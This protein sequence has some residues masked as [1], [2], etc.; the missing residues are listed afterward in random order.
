MYENPKRIVATITRVSPGYT[1]IDNDN[2]VSS[3]KRV[4]DAC[5]EWIG[6]DDGSSVYEW[7]VESRCGEW[8]V[9][10]ELDVFS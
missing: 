5:A 4:R 3:A 10:I 6:I 9:E 1:P 2:A 8:A 7:N